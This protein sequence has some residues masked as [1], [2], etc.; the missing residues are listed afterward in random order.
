[1]P[2]PPPAP[3]TA[4]AASKPQDAPVDKA[5]IADAKAKLV[6]KHGDAHRA[7]IERGVD[8]VASLWRASDGDL[9]AFCVEQFLPDQ[10]QRDALFERMQSIFEQM[11]GHF[12]ELGRSARWNTEVDTGPLLAVDPLLAAYDPGAHATEDMFKTRIA[13]AVLLNFP[14]TKLADRL[15]NGEHY[16]RDGYLPTP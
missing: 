11:A 7:E 9:A 8:Q 4:T 15:Q 6:A 13:F 12:L 10:K 3:V 2:C 16:S 5:A 1:M 14:L